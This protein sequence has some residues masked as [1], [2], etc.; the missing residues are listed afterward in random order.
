MQGEGVDEISGEDEAQE[1][2][3][4]GEEGQEE[5]GGGA[6]FVF[7]LARVKKIMRIDGGEK[8]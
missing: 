8:L 7:P 2:E 1:E 3:V 5:E 6:V 4:T